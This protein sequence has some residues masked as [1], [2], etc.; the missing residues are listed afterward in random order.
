MP[1]TQ[2]FSI[3]VAYHTA[4]RWW[5]QPRLTACLLCGTRQVVYRLDWSSHLAAFHTSQATGPCS[6]HD[7][8]L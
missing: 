6:L 5:L 1:T 4:Q 3:Y 2:S 8:H 7:Q